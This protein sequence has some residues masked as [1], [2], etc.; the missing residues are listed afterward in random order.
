MDLVGSGPLCPEVRSAALVDQ[1]WLTLRGSVPSTE[2]RNLLAVGGVFLCTSQRESFGIAIAEALGAGLPVVGG[3]W[4]DLVN[5]AA[6]DGGALCVGSME[7][8]DWVSALMDAF[9]AESYRAR[10]EAAKRFARTHFGR[11]A[12]DI[13]LAAAYADG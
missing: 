12:Q 2:V 4:I 7:V 8:E 11:P 10:S 13:A 6:Q 1:H 5:R 3:D 9:R